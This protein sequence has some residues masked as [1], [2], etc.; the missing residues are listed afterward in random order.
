MAGK[1]APPPN[2]D[3]EQLVKKRFLVIEVDDETGELTVSD[4]GG[5][6]GWEQVGIAAWLDATA[7]DYLTEDD[8]D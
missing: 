2:V 8:D 3:L 1:E 6:T 7:R 4:D 5:I